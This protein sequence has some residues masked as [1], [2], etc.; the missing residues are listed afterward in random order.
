[1]WSRSFERRAAGALFMALVGSSPGCGQNVLASP[2]SA[3]DSRLL[4][5]VLSR[6]TI[7]V[8]AACK[9]MLHPVSS[10]I[11][12]ES[13][14]E[15]DCGSGRCRSSQNPSTAKSLLSQLASAGSTTLFPKS[16]LPSFFQALSAKL[17]QMNFI[18]PVSNYS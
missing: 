8:T 13:T 1:M 5:G 10:L 17:L 4:R 11:S 15:G 14:W 7:A 18:L 9:L 12:T 6:S 2:G 16:Q 3:A